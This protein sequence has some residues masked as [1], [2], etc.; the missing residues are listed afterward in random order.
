MGRYRGLDVTLVKPLTY[1]NESGIAVRK[2]LARERAPLLAAER[3]QGEGLGA[4]HVRG[5]A[6]AEQHPRGGAGDPVIGQPA[7]GC[8]RKKARLAQR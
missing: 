3:F 8:P 6:A 2:I 4:G 5:V 1:M 7:P